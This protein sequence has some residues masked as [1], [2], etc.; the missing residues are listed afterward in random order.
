MG[1]EGR[2][3]SNCVWYNSALISWRRQV[4]VML[5][6]MA[7]VW[8]PRTDPTNRKF[9]RPRAMR[10]IS[11]SATL[12]SMRTAESLVKTFRDS[13]WFRQYLNAR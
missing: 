9:F 1:V 8:P 4:L 2:L 12:L 11:C 6:R 3:A 5:A 10:F 13:H 7:A